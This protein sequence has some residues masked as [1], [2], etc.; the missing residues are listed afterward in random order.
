M[1]FLFG[2]WQFFYANIFTKPE[3]FV[4]LIVLVGYLLLGR[5]WY[6]ALAGFIKAVVGYMILN[7]AAG[8]LVSN[9]RPILVALADRF[10]LQAA[11]IDPYFGQA[12]AE[13]ALKEAGHATGLTVQV[14]LVAFLANLALVI[15][16]RFTKV[17]TVFITGHIMVQQSA[18]ATWLLALALGNDVNQLQFVVV[19]GIV[20]GVYWAVA[21]NLT[22]EATQEL[23]EGGGFAIGHQQMFGI[24][25]ADKLAPKL[26]GK[27]DRKIEDLELPGFLSIFKESIVATS[28]L[29][30]VFFGAILLI[31]GKDYLV[32][33]NGQE[34]LKLK[35]TT[36]KETD[37]FFFYI[38]KVALT[39][40]VYIQ[41]LQL[42]VRMFVAELSE[43]FQGISNKLLPG[44]MPAVDCAA[45]YGFGSPNAVTIGFLFGV[46]GQLVAI[47]GLIVFKS[48]VFIITGFVPVFFD[49]ATF[50][51]YANHKGGLRAASILTFASGVIQVLGGA[52]AAGAFGLAKFGGWHGNFD[53]DTVWVGFGFLMQNLHYVGLGVV[54]VILLAIPQLQYLK[55]KEHY[56][57]IAEDY[58]AYLEAKEA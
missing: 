1:E 57:T 46:L 55:N 56:F 25:L 20:L 47:I 19:L 33:V 50:A 45:V 32:S 28:I 18:T 9:F 42:G 11:V 52:L 14:L 12:A 15:F 13:A 40:T 37:D 6:D 29:M 41:V 4:G 51:V 22:V 36:L 10:Q 30:I 34:I 21:S 16:R 44:S 24:W 38:M 31:L 39:F 27:N 2:F 5:K 43:A 49:N 8:G 23:T 3:Y 26:S 17:R 7:V 35:M 53:W 48:S 58:E 54:L